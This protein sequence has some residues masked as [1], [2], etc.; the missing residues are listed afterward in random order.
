MAGKKGGENTKKAAG[1]ARKAQ[2]AADKAAAEDQKK[3]AA[4]D[5][6][7][8]KGSK[9]NSKKEAQAAKKA[10]QAKKKAERT[11]ALAEEEE[12]LPSRAGPKN[13][14]TAVKKTRRGIDSALTETDDNKKAPELS[15]SGLDNALAV[16]SV[17]DSKSD[18]K[19]DRHADRRVKAAYTA[20]EERRLQEMKE[21]GSGKGMNYGSKKEKIW[22]EFKNSPENP[23]RNQLAVKHNATKEEIAELKEQEKARLEALY[24]S[25]P[26]N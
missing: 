2:A 10:E 13:A 1:Q 16:L 19:I 24:S 3:A 6:E 14:K 12:S 11:A 25:K 21:D 26:S 8:D 7:W 22:K 4:E 17:D 15:G 5:A 23:A 9:N 20:F 18:V